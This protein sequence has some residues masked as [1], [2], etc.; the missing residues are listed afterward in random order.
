[1]Q[2]KYQKYYDSIINRRREQIIS[3]GYYEMHHIIPKSLGGS[4]LNINLIA[5]TAREHLVVHKLLRKITL[6]EYG[7]NS[8]QYK[9][10]TYA[11]WQMSNRDNNVNLYMSSREYERLR[12]EFSHLQRERFLGSRNPMYGKTQKLSTRNKISCANKCKIT[13]MKGRCHTDKSREKMSEHH[14]DVTGDKNPMYGK[15]H[16]QESI[17][18]MKEHQWDRSGSKNPRYGK[19]MSVEEKRHLSE[20]LSGEKHP[21]YGKKRP[22]HSQK[23][24]GKNNPAFGRRWMYNPI[25]KEKIYSKKEDIQKYL[26]LGFILGTGKKE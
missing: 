13:W 14:V 21:M 25:T 23:M 9:S 15:K 8:K 18:K 10:M 6:I 22:E 3:S 2:N 17:Q 1:M 5:L 20:M 16:R 4:N 19:K 26:D 12:I 11:L 7:S 24:M